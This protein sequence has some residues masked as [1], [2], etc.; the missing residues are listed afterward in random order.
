MRLAIIL[1]IS[2]LTGLN[3][4]RCKSY[5]VTQ[6]ITEQRAQNEKAKEIA[7]KY[8]P[9]GPMLDSIITALDGS[10]EL[11]VETDKERQKEKAGKEE[12]KIRADKNAGAAH[13]IFWAKVA[14]GLAI[15]SLSFYGLKKFGQKIP[16][17][18]RFF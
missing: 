9:L 2:G 5:D 10:S 12:E 8:V 11:L 15:A 18:G 13:T 16:I 4:T 6:K 17:I 3:L 7:K 1:C 14:A